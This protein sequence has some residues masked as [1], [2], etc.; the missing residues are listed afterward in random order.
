MVRVGTG[1]W[2]WAIRIILSGTILVWLV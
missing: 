1:H 2:R